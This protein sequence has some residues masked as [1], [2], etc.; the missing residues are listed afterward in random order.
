MNALN[1]IIFAL[2]RGWRIRGNSFK[3]R[4]MVKGQTMTKTFLALLLSGDM[5]RLKDADAWVLGK[6][7]PR[8]VKYHQ[9]DKQL[10]RLAVCQ[11]LG[12]AA[13]RAYGR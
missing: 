2:D 1:D 7:S 9:F 6:L 13:L 5:P 3:Y 4:K 11:T 10:R 12:G 8:E